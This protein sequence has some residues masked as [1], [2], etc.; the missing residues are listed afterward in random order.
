M[1]T[2]TTQGTRR[3]KPPDKLMV[4]YTQLRLDDAQMQR[5]MKM[6]DSEIRKLK[7]PISR[8][9]VIRKCID[10]GLDVWERSQ[11]RSAPA[12]AEVKS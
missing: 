3:T 7:Y 1:S 2:G 9:H 10:I 8:S 5:L 6:Q 4:K 11:S 12:Q